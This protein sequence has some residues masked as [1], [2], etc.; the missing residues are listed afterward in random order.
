[1]KA[2]LLRRLKRLGEVRATERRLLGVQ[3]GYLSELAVGI[4]KPAWPSD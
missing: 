1:M 4:G 3:F 2:A